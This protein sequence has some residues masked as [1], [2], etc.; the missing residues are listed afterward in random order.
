[1]HVTVIMRTRIFANR[2]KEWHNLPLI[3]RGYDA[4][5]IWWAKKARVKKQLSRATD[6][7][8]S[9]TKYNM[10]AVTNVYAEYENT[11]KDFSANNA[12]QQATMMNMPL[13]IPS[14]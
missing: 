6:N 10:G 3:Q 2:Y 9:S 12:A 13:G 5:V 7:M 1:M 8:G 4:V 11:V 14:I